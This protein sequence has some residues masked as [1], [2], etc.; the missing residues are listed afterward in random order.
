LVIE[1]RRRESNPRTDFSNQFS[2]QELQS[3]QWSGAAP[4]QQ[5]TGTEGQSESLSGTQSNSLSASVRRIADRWESL[6]PHIR[7]AILTL[8]DAGT[9]AA[10]SRH[11]CGG[12]KNSPLPDELAWRLARKCRGIVQACLREEEWLDADRELFGVIS[13]GLAEQVV[14]K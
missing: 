4:E 14:D 11:E 12:A 3:E 8:V 2:Q 1:W 6:R 7:E 5:A 9:V 10:D 13:E